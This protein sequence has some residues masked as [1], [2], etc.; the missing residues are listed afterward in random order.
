[1]KSFF[2][3]PLGISSTCWFIIGLL[4]YLSEKIIWFFSGKKRKKNRFQVKDIAVII[5]AHNE[6]LAIGTCIKALRLSF[7]ADQLH[8]AS[9][10]SS[11]KTVILARRE[12]V[13]VATIHPGLGKARAILTTIK[14]F[15]IYKRYKM[16]FIVDSDTRIDKNFL[17]YALPLFNDPKV[18]VT[19]GS[20]MIT[21]P[22][23]VLPKLK[24]FFVAYRERLNRL[25]FFFFT[26]GQTWKYTNMTYVIP[27]FSTLWRVTIFKKIPFDTPGLLIEDFNTAFYI[28]K[29]KLCRIAYNPRC[30]GWDQHPETLGDYWRQVRRWNIGFFQ[31]IKHNGIWPSFYWFS[32]MLFSL[33]VFA[34]SFLMLGLPFLI[35]YLVFSHVFTLPQ[36]TTYIMVPHTIGPYQEFTFL[37]LLVRFYIIDYGFTVL[38]GLMY[39]KPQFLFYGLFFVFMHYVTSLILISSLIPGFFSTSKGRWD[40]PKRSLSQMSVK[41]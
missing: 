12:G 33:E 14:R 9:D 6:E 21:W 4:R 20:A 36:L 16:I 28:H 37:D 3:L 17:F 13:H 2:G 39:K 19:Y 30:I 27:G 11:D 25:L 32:L 8:V 7:P 26:Y 24:Y 22:M 34:N 29:H 35:F 31:T 41:I 5:A 18:G 1:M 40:S 23:H 10:G 15:R 38:I